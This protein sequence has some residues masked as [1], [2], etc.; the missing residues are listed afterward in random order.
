[1]QKYEGKMIINILTKTK[2]GNLF[3]V[4]CELELRLEADFPS[5]SLIIDRIG[6]QCPYLF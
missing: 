2:A 3:K 6:S 5:K 1:M 4:I